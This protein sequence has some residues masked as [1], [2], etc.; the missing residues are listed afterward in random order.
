M[1]VCGFK[2]Q[3]KGSLKF[4]NGFSEWQ[5]GQPFQV[6]IQLAGF[7]SAR[8][9]TSLKAS[10]LFSSSIILVYNKPTE[11]WM[12]ERTEKNHT[13]V[14]IKFTSTES[15]ARLRSY[16]C[17]TPFPVL[18]LHQQS[19]RYQNLLHG[20]QYLQRQPHWYRLTG[21][22]CYQFLIQARQSIIK[23]LLDHDQVFG[24]QRV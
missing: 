13:H 15:L 24:L 5:S 9:L 22:I 14:Q 16:V 12:R 2:H 7:N 8:T 10:N 21:W 23:C 17:H 3:S 11:Q 6:Q 18:H 19:N 4:Q 20:W 1:S